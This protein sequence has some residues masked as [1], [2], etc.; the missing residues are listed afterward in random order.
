MK[1]L[2]TVM[3]RYF[4]VK[5]TFS[6]LGHAL[7]IN[8]KMTKS[9]EFFLE[10]LHRLRVKYGYTVMQ[11]VQFFVRTTRTFFLLVLCLK[12]L[13]FRVVEEEGHDFLYSRHRQ[14]WFGKKYILLLI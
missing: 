1:I 14:T 13:L 6:I 11:L 3:L 9:I 7:Q 2:A 12:V 4:Q 5:N 8:R 10:S